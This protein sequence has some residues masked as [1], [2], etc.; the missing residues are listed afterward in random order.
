MSSLSISQYHHP[1]GGP[2]PVSWEDSVVGYPATLVTTAPYCHLSVSHRMRHIRA[3]FLEQMLGDLLGKWSIGEIFFCRER[4]APPLDTP[5]TRPPWFPELKKYTFTHSN[6]YPG[7]GE[8][9]EVMIAPFLAFHESES[10]GTWKDSGS[11]L[12]TLVSV[13]LGGARKPE[14]G[15]TF[16]ER[17]SDVANIAEQSYTV[18][19]C[20]EMGTFVM[21][22]MKFVEMNGAIV[23]SVSGPKRSDNISECPSSGE[24]ARRMN[25]TINET[26]AQHES[27]IGLGVS[28]I[29]VDIYM[30]YELNHLSAEDCQK[31]K[32]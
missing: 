10:L 18:W 1:R 22:S 21:V 4:A 14:A 16:F 30:P 12:F 9:G 24:V 13:A 8:A 3:T 31:Y 26:I 5:N 17:D 19:A 28:A 29:E 2:F 27:A 23:V 6:L 32:N 15:Q 20:G 7:E 11:Q 25:N